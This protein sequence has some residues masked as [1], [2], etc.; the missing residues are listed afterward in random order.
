M[1]EVAY[2]NGEILPIEQARVPVEDRGYQFG[3]AVYEYL[4]AYDGHIFALEAHLDRLQNSLSALDFPS[5]SRNR[6]REAILSTHQRSAIK[7]AGIYLQISRGVAPRNHIWPKTIAPQFVITIRQRPRIDPQWRE[8]GISAITVKDFRWGRCDIKTVQ[9][10]ANTLARQQASQVQAHDAI[11]ISAIDVVREATSSNVFIVTG[12]S[13]ITH[14]LTPNIL[15]GITRAELIKLSKVHDIP[16]FEDFFSRSDLLEADEVFLSGTVTEV[17]PVTQIDGRTI[18]AGTPGPI[19][20]RLH[21]YLLKEASP[22][23]R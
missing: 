22:P 20:Q 21:T 5:I 9:L 18:G 6:I 15:P 8:Q 4:A 23:K 2:L 11:F 19:A 3:D 14:P 10:L 16:T 7:Q 13:L 17:L 1:P 12:G